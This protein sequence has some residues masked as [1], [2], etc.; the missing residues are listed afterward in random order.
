MSIESGFDW[1]IAP[2][3]T[4]RLTIDIDEKLSG[5]QSLADQF[6]WRLAFP[7][8]TVIKH[9]RLSR[10]RLTKSPSAV[11]TKDLITGGPPMLVVNDATN[12]QLLGKSENFPNCLQFPWTK[13][14]INFTTLP[15]SQAAVIRL[16][17]SSCDSSPCPIFG[18]LWLDEFSVEQTETRRQR[19]KL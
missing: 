13:L 16:Q 17:R 18:T 10:T 11:K 4:S 12:N 2:S 9:F 3:G 14:T 6:Q 15:T 19:G 7:G 8:T 5:Q 1:I